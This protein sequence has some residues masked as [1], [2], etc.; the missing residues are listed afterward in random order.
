[1]KSL[2]LSEMI[3]AFDSE[4]SDE[5]RAEAHRWIDERDAGAWTSATEEFQGVLGD[6]EASPEMLDFAIQF[7][8]DWCL[9]R[10]RDF[11]AQRP[12]ADEAEDFFASVAASDKKQPEPIFGVFFPEVL[13]Q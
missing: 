12:P 8:R 13:G 6:R 11:K 7:Y 9:K 10:Y 4:L 5:K 3:R 2:R 1:M